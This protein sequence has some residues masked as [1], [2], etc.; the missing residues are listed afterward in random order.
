MIEVHREK[1]ATAT[2]VVFEAPDPQEVGVVEMDEDGRISRLVEKPKSSIL[3]PQ[4]PTLANGGVYV[5]ERDVLDYI[6]GQGFSDFA[7]DI[8]PKLIELGLPVYGYVLKPE[9][10]LID[11]GSVDKYDKA[12]EDIKNSSRTP[13]IEP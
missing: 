11:I 2:L 13:N 10:Y 1:K 6:P 9:D 5:L 12:N 4:P 7:Y 3:S 8:F